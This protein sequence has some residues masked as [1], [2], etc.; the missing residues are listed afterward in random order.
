[1]SGGA[2][3]LS[4]MMNKGKKLTPEQKDVVQESIRQHNS[5]KAWEQTKDFT[6]QNSKGRY[7]SNSSTSS[8]SGFNNFNN[9]RFN[10]MRNQYMNN[11]DNVSDRKWY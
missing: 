11:K 6:N 5:R 9:M 2:S 7:G 4:N 3:I 8:N 10:T 1:M